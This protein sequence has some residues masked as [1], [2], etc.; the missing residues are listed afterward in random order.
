MSLEKLKE[1]RQCE[2]AVLPPGRSEL[3]LNDGG[4]L[5]LRIRPGDNRSWEFKYTSAG[6][7]HKLGLGG[8]PAVSLA[9]ARAA[10]AGARD[11]LAQGID[12]REERRKRQEEA[13]ATARRRKT[14]G[15]LAVEWIEQAA[16]DGNWSSSY[17]ERQVGV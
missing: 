8:Y 14:F 1:A 4:G 2:V 7:A 6:V 16:I 10:A 13:A 15:D 5:Y 11:L 9:G 12:P 17:R 3:H